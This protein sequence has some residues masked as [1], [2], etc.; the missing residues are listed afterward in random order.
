[1]NPLLMLRHCNYPLNILF[2]MLLICM[3]LCSCG[4]RTAQRIVDEGIAVHGGSAYRSFFLRFDFRDRHYT[5]A[6]Q[7]GIFTYTREFTDSTGRIKDVLNNDG[8][9][10][11]KNNS[12]VSLADERKKAF[13]SSINS[14]I[15][16][17][18]LPFGLNDDPVNKEWIN[19]TTIRG[20]AYNVVRV[21]FDEMGEGSDHRDIFLYWF[22]KTRHTMD[23]FAYSYESDGGGIRFREA[24]NPRKTG[25]ILLQ[26]YINYKPKHDSTSIED[27]QSLFLSGDLEKLSEIRMEN[28]VVKNDPEKN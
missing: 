16:F 1:M 27:L 7:D 5:V 22:H 3:L 21:T 4:D 28:V 8:L 17:A 15:Y 2:P 19:E 14:V 25:G 11:Y 26:D 23:Y 20:E 10:R 12:V 18:L 6:R 13:A 24:V 9:T